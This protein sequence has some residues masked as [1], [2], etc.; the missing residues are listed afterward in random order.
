MKILLIYAN[1]YFLNHPVY[2]FGLNL[3]ADYLRNRGHE[4][5]IELPF[6]YDKKIHRGIDI[7]LNKFNPDLIG[8]SIRNIDTAMACEKFGTWQQ[9]GVSTHFFLPDIRKTVLAVKER[10]PGIPVVVGGPGFSVSPEEILTYVQ[11]DYGIRGDGARPMGKLIDCLDSKT[12]LDQVDNLLILKENTRVIKTSNKF[13]TDIDLHPVQREK[14]FGYAFTVSAMPVQTHYGCAMNCAY[15]VEP[16]ITQKKIIFRKKEKIIQELQMIAQNY[17]DVSEIFFVDTE[18]NSPD[19]DFSSAL[20][21]DILKAKLEKRFQF[22]SQFLPKNMTEEYASLLSRTGFYVILTCDSFSDT[23]LA[24]NHCPYR[25]K[26]ILNTLALFEKYQVNS[27]LNLIFGLPAETLA[28]MD[29]TIGQINHFNRKAGLFKFEYTAGARVYKNTPLAGYM[30]KKDNTRFLFG[31]KSD[32]FLTPVFFSSPVSPFEIHDYVRERLEFKIDF[33]P[34]DTEKNRAVC[35]IAFYADNELFENSCRE[36]CRADINV[37]DA[38]F[39][40]L[41]RKYNAESRNNVFAQEISQNFLYAVETCDSDGRF[42]HRT[43]MLHYFLSLL[44]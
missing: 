24:E 34:P 2:P 17:P 7:V 8:I 5:Q 43:E 35:N 30:E 38:V 14:S 42:S 18:F 37:K 21:K 23:V 6:I 27:S 1:R 28:T 20:L 12:D 19:S 29:H 4:V 15:C 26:D 41:F 9:N 40:Y 13:S 36:F 11:A 33:K 25:E 39:D 10:L 16:F 3:I 22:T 44:Q 31:E 32:N